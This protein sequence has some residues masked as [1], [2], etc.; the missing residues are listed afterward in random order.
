MTRVD[1][2]QP[3]HLVEYLLLHFPDYHICLPF[4]AAM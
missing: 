1:Q 4:I 3:P 2:T